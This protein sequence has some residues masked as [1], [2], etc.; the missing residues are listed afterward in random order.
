MTTSHKKTTRTIAPD[1]ELL[2]TAAAIVA[3]LGGWGVLAAREQKAAAPD[4]AMSSATTII[5]PNISPVATL[6]PLNPV[7][8][9]RTAIK[10]L[11]AAP[12][13]PAIRRIA[14]P[15]APVAGLSANPS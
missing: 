8:N 5:V 7:T 6:V 11:E 1:L 15:P 12:V 2:I 9:D 14:A 4:M 3:T 13:A 10:V